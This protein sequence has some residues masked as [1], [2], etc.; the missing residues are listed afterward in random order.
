MQEES[1]YTGYGYDMVEVG[2]LYTHYYTY[3]VILTYEYFTLYTLKYKSAETWQF[4]LILAI[5]DMSR[6]LSPVTYHHN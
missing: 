2:I 6:V 4:K 3:I 5:Q 1:S